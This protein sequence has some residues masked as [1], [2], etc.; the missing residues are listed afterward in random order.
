[1]PLCG[2]ELQ[3]QEQNYSLILDV[4]LQG[5]IA[6][7]LLR[8]ESGTTEIGTEPPVSLIERELH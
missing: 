4:L 2:E 7:I 5:E 1:M 6:G 3:G 8:T